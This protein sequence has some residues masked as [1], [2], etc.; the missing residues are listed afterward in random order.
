MELERVRPD[1]FRGDSRPVGA[2]AF[3]GA[4]ESHWRLLPAAIL[5]TWSLVNFGG[6]FERKKWTL[7]SELVRLAAASA[8]TLLWLRDDYRLAPLPVVTAVAVL[9]AMFLVLKWRSLI[10]PGPPPEAA[11]DQFPASTAPLG[12]GGHHGTG[13]K[14]N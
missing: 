14:L 12:A 7:A 11:L 3:V 2:V 1:P 4:A 13:S 5:T 9:S 6:I 10:E 8:G